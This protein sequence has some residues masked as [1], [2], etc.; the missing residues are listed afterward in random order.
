MAMTTTPAV[1]PFPLYSARGSNRDLGLQHG[2]QARE[3]IRAH[4]DALQRSLGLATAA[5]EE[6]AL[7]FQPL[8]EE[9]CPHLVEEIEGLARGAGISFAGGLA[10][11]TRGALGAPNAAVDGGCTAFVIGREAAEQGEVLIGQTS[12]MLPETIDFAYV[13]RLHPVDKTAML[14]WTFG[15]MI[16]YHGLNALGV[17]HMANDLGD[18]G[19]GRRFAM[20]H[21]P[22]KR[23]M[24]ECTTVA[25][26]V[27]LLRRVPLWSNGNYVLCDGAG[28]ILD[29]EATSAGPELIEDDGR[30]YITHTNHYCSARYATE[31]NA[32]A[33]YADSFPRLARIN[34]FLAD[35]SGSFSVGD[36]RA[37]LSDHA[38]YP[39]SICRHA[40][41]SNPDD[42]FETA[43]VTAAALIAEPEQGRLHIAPGN[44]CSSPFTTYELDA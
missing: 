36:L 37:A 29:I 7:A 13:L 14:M 17:A 5:F 8:F 32:A 1:Q 19:P 15:G 2:E 4:L 34:A 41:S 11:N 6:R 23:M 16:G 35:R 39:T 40:S 22:V 43:G 33:T 20:P 12:D 27:A 30:G 9:H 31:E 24:Y 10:I 28:S 18:G 44:P 25:E 26:V 38:N 3:Q 21:Y 42:G